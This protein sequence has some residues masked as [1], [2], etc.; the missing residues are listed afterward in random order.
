MFG[1]NGRYGKRRQQ[2]KSGAGK[3]HRR[4]HRQSAETPDSY[5]RL[6]A[7]P[8]GSKS[9]IIR[10]DGHGKLRKRL[11]E[12]G[13]IENAVIKTIKYAPLYDPIEFL[14]K[15]YHVSLRRSEAEQICVEPLEIPVE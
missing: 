11:L 1:L 14:I 15:G 8:E 13:F 9:R 6:N 2:S 5:L 7:C 12:M 3:Q 10:I 4:R